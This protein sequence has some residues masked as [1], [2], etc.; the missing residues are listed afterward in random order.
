MSDVPRFEPLIDPRPDAQAW[1]S[2]IWPPAADVVLSNEWIELRPCHVDDAQGMLHALDHDSVWAHIPGRHVTLAQAAE[3][4]EQKRTM[5]WFPWTVR[6]RQPVGDFAA[7]DI[8]GTTS[9]LEV[10]PHDARLEI[11]STMYSPSVWASFVNP[12]TKLL[13]L[14]FAFESL[15]MN[16]V[17]LKCDVRN[18]RSQKA[19]ARLGA[20]CEGLIRQY[21][22]RADGTIRDTVL[23]S[24]VDTEWPNI[25]A[26][27]QQRLGSE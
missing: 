15:Y 20:Q 12:A 16:R 23:F 21:Q 24:I 13:L 9:F 7:G 4:F 19:I 5:G 25:R 6:T 17:Q 8:V 11:G 3:S 22:R 1:P 26:T 27:L 2:A 10:S 14:Q 18:V